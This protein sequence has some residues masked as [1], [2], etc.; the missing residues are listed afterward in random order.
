MNAPRQAAYPHL[1][2]F[3]LLSVF[4]FPGCRREL[5][6][7]Q[8]QEPQ[9]SQE[10]LTVNPLSISNVQKAIGIVAQR[11]H[12]AA[13]MRT[14]AN[15][16]LTVTLDTTS[17]S[18]PTYV[19]FKFD[20]AN[21]T[22]A[23]VQALESDT[24]FQ[25][26]EI[27]FADP[28]IYSDSTL[29]S[30]AIEALKDGKIYAVAA[31]DNPLVDT[32][33]NATNLLPQV[34]DTLVLIPEED[35]ALQ[36]AAMEAAG[37]R[38]NIFGICLLKRPHGY[39]RY[40]D[41]DLNNGAGQFEPVRNMQVWALVFGIPVHTY[42]DAN[43]YYEVPWRFS[44]GTIMGTKAKNSR[45]TIKPLDTHG[46][47]AGTAIAL[48]T[49]F[50]TGSIHIDGWVGTCTMRD[51]KD[52]NF[53]GH[54]QV[55]YWSQLLNAYYFHDVYCAQEG[56]TNAPQGLICYAQWA[57]FSTNKFGKASTPLL[58][59][60]SGS[61]IVPNFINNLFGGVNVQTGFPNLFNVLESVLPDMTFSVAQQGEPEHYTTRLAQTA[62]HE[63]GHASHYQKVG[64]GWWLQLAIDEI[65]DHSV[66]GNPYGDGS[67]ADDARISLAESW[68]QYI[69][70]EFAVRRYPI[71][72]DFATNGSWSSGLHAISSMLENESYF[73]GGQWMPYGLFHDF[74]DG[75]NGNEVWDNVSGVSIQQ[76]Y[77]NFSSAVDDWCEYANNFVSNYGAAF[78]A[79][80][81]W[82]IFTSYS[83]NCGVT[84]YSNAGFTQSI[85]KNNCGVN[86]TGS[87]VNVT[88]P[89]GMFTSLVS[90]TD[91]DQQAQAYAQIVANNN[92]TCNGTPVP[93]NVTNTTNKTINLTFTKL[94]TNT[95]YNFSVSP[96]STLTGT[97]SAGT[98]DVFMTPVGYSSTY[99]V[100]YSLDGII[101]TYYATVMFGS[102]LINGSACNVV[103][104]PPAAIP[105]N[106]SNTTTK[107]MQYVFTNMTTNVV[108]TFTVNP[109]AGLS[110]SLPE[111]TYSVTML[112]TAY[113]QSYP[114][115]YKLN[116]ST[117][118]YYATVTFGGVLINST[119]T[120]TTSPP[121]SV[122]ATVANSTSATMTLTFAN[123]ATNYSYVF[124]ASPGTSTFLV[125]EGNYNVTISPNSYSAS[126][127]NYY[128]I[129]TFT[130]TYY[131]AV[132]FGGVAI[133]STCPISIHK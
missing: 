9:A 47:L 36:A 49:H 41:Q 37:V 22:Q 89:A 82:Q 12:R 69:G 62:F 42:T 3:F 78:R 26:M 102:Y 106:I 68:A 119:C 113:T 114:I 34:L 2:V 27:P 100:K 127:P 133:S 54:T 108:T 40:W 53:S 123:L 80:N 73:H 64:A 85:Q 66:P 110:T 28:A 97:L 57:N 91:A 6:E 59:H 32:L 14:D 103:V 48:V 120:I 35:T 5:H 105:V 96:G 117:Q 4:L 25:L 56:I 131:A 93:L 124:S 132:V 95:S 43:G 107:T 126:S 65:P 19:Y 60:I 128:S 87:F 72:V 86:E 109:G 29:D 46:T 21:I 104:S 121:P 16:R 15:A 94:S 88:V 13:S 33:L 58:N 98:Y 74:R 118:V 55:R 70:N 125:P 18:Y 99:P 10:R 44:I 7:K 31:A 8:A 38:V 52:F 81:S 20:P 71:G 112:P 79:S 101:Q 24:T 90:P 67:H 61:S 84:L 30:T 1:L 76:L 63:L 11:T 45:V 50:I 77:N 122:T 17:S 116:T 39:V 115:V 51:G 130:Q 83:I 23:Q 75:Y 129:Y 111:D 92:G